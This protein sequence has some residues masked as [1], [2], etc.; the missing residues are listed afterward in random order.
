MD[1][2][3]PFPWRA[4]CAVAACVLLVLGGLVMLF[5]GRIQIDAGNVGVVA[6]FGAI[7]THQQ[8]LAPGFHVVNPFATQVTT[9]ST[10]PQNHQFSEVAASSRELQNVYV[11]GGVNYHIDAAQAPEIVTEGGLDAVV[12][13][14]F[15]PAFQDYIKEV[16]P[17][18]GA[19]DV[20][21]QRA[22]IRDTTLAELRTKAGTYGIHVDDLFITNIHFDKAYTDAIEKAAVSQQQLVQAQ[23]EAKTKVAQAQGD[24]DANRLRQQTLTPE[25]LQYMALQ[26]QQAAVA[27]WDGKLPST[28]LGSGTNHPVRPR[29]VTGATEKG[30][31]DD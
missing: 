4:G 3:S 14:V 1:S 8:P 11:D 9:I 28:E 29:E 31:F 19:Q 13:K 27:K 2:D 10:Q 25:Q 22:A 24:A 5:G 17:H 12:A 23:N 18:Y 16:V 21:A 20:L 6:E 7:D 26:N 30:R 15:N